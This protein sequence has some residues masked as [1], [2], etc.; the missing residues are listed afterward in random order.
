M[1]K[2]KEIYKTYDRKPLLKGISFDVA[3]GEIVCLLGSSGSGKSTMLRII[4]GLEMADGGSLFWDGEDLSNTPVH[5]RNFGLMFQ[6]YA[7]FPHRSVAQNVAFGLRMQGMNKKEIEVRV[8]EQ[9]NRV[10]LTSFASRRVTGLSGGEQ[11]RVAFARALAPNPRLLMLDEP[12]G[13]LDRTLREQLLDELRRMLRSTAVPT[14]YV[15]HDQ[16]E[17]FVLADRLLIL[18]D[19]V[20]EQSGTPKQ[21][22]DQP[23]TSWV[24]RFLGLQNLLPG[25]VISV[26]PLKIQTKAGEFDTLIH[27]STYSPSLGEDVMVLI[28]PMVDLSDKRLSDYQNLTGKAED[29]IFRGNDYQ[30]SLKLPSGERLQFFLS[31]APVI[32]ETV[33]LYLKAESV[34]CLRNELNDVGPQ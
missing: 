17:A 12:L 28:R 13:A 14:I 21:V 32:G 4:A 20:I 16:E 18:K 3:Q 6:D 25:K 34:I 30:L 5:Q 26:T 29:V 23:R 33:T 8:Q 31:E 2:V 10:D 7:L 1:L 15:T 11:Q 9:L 19:G 27:D 22:F 24:A